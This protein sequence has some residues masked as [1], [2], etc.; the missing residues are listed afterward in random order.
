[1]FDAVPGIFKSA[2]AAMSV[3]KAYAEEEGVTWLVVYKSVDDVMW[4]NVCRLKDLPQA[5]SEHWVR[6]SDDIKSA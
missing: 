3:A 4:F 6:F 5:V 2:S 1:M